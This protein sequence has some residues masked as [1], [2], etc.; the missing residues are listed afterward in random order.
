MPREFASTLMELLPASLTD[1]N[2]KPRIGLPRSD[3]GL[4][5]WP[6]W[7]KAGVLLLMLAAMLPAM[8]VGLV[9]AVPAGLCLLGWEASRA[10]RQRGG[11]KPAL[12]RRDDGID[13]S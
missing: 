4:A 3:R 9:L 1:E 11:L 7:A 2:G 13:R 8:A 6:L 12:V 5:R 10:L